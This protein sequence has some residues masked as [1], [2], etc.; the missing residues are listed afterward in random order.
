MEVYRNWQA[1]QT[2]LC[3]QDCW[4]VT[5]KQQNGSMKILL[6][7]PLKVGSLEDS[8]KIS[9]NIRTRA[10]TSAWLND[11]GWSSDLQDTQILDP[12]NQQFWIDQDL[13]SLQ[14]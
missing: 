2:S 3:T 8:I 5:S 6:W 7:L 12:C 1:L 11:P 13:H 4:Q 14:N 9:L 10:V